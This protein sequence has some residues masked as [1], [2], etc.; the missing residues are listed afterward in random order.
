MMKAVVGALTIVMVM[1][2][3]VHAKSGSPAKPASPAPAGKPLPV[4]MDNFIRAESDL[5][6]GNVVKDKGF[7][8]FAH[9]RQVTPVSKQP[10]V[11]MNRD[12]LYSSAIFDLDAGPVAITL[13]DSG[14][15]FMSMQVITEDHFTP[16]VA[17]KPGNYALTREEIDT[18][19]VLVAI[20]TLVDPA[21]PSDLEEVHALQDTIKVEQAGVGKFEVPRWDPVSQKK[22]R[23]ALIVLGTTLSDSKHMFGTKE[24]VTPLRHLIGSAVGWGGNPDTEATYLGVTPERNDGNQVYKL[25]LRDVPVDGFWSITVYNA[26]GY[27]EANRYDTYSLNSITA[28]KRIDGSVTVQFGG[29]NGKIANC[30]PIMRGWNY[31]VRLYRPQPE[32]LS[33]GWVFPEAQPVK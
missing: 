26:K 4:T 17:Y 30:L 24:Q 22:I 2:V 14:T 20:R 27:L 8:R 31:T 29:C 23:E 9:N 32:I 28:K 5:Y 19:Y 25:T 11:R 33:G 16:L 7:G 10:I 13:P 15:R 18:R 12:T 21:D 6:F 1:S 3:G